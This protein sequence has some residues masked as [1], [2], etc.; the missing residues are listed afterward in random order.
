LTVLTSHHKPNETG[1]DIARGRES[2]DRDKGSGKHDDGAWENTNKSEEYSLKITLTGPTKE[3]EA[4]SE[5][6]IDRD[7]GQE[8]GVITVKAGFVVGGEAA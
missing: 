4:D 6:A 5:P 7:G 3:L 1:V 8:A 2:D